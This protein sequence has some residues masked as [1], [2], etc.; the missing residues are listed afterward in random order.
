MAVMVFT[1]YCQ[2]NLPFFY[3]SRIDRYA[4]AISLQK[5]L[6]CNFPVTPLCYLLQFQCLHMKVFYLSVTSGL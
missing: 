3:V 6:I 2:K 1:L 5:V 4:A